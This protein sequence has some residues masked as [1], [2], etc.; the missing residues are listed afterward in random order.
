MARRVGTTEQLREQR[1]WQMQRF[2]NARLNRETVLRSAAIAGI[3][4][5]AIRNWCAQWPDIDRIRVAVDTG[6]LATLE[7]L[8]PQYELAADLAGHMR[9]QR[10]ASE[11]PSQNRPERGPGRDY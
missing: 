5:G 7:K 10:S 11:D 3:S 8:A 9:E 6:D 2:L 1:R 4:L